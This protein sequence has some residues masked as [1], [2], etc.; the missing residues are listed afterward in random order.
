MNRKVG[1]LKTNQTA[2]FC[3]LGSQWGEAGSRDGAELHRRQMEVGEV[4]DQPFYQWCR[5]VQRE[6]VE[7][8]HPDSSKG[9]SLL[10]DMF[11]L[12]SLAWDAQGNLRNMHRK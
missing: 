2:A 10:K 6:D 9:T 4:E 11:L 3:Q 7:K 1:L 8:C 12:S 5:E